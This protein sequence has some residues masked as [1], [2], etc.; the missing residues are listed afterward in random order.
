M[1]TMRV[2]ANGA[3][4]EVVVQG[5]GEPVVLVQTALLAEELAPLA[6]QPVLKTRYQLIRYHRRGYAGSSPMSGARSIEEEAADC[7]ALLSSLGIAR[8]HVVGLSFS[9][10]IVLQLAVAA[11]DLVHTLALL[12]PPPLRTPS[13]P[14][15]R[16][17]SAE[18][19]ADYRDRGPGPA[20]DAFL[21]RIVGPDWRTAAGEVLPTTEE[22]LHSALATFLESDMPALLRWGFDRDD[23]TRVT[24]PVLYVGGADSGRWFAEGRDLML[25]WL[26]HAE[27]VV[28]PGASHSFAT[29]HPSQVA[30][31][32]DGF[33]RRHPLPAGRP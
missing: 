11:P 24:Q 26:P 20:V 25:S 21:T 19:L 8:A 28:L 13:E 33:L 5:S 2:A 22:Q 27:N 10:A 23:A 4:L 6:R 15:F 3:D 32:L 7:R 31:A 9:C 17:A 29:T 1:S 30:T 16:A 18:V 12:E 14:E